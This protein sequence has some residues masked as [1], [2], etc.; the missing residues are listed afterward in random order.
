M[1][2]PSRLILPLMAHS[3]GG[4]E[5][6][7]AHAP[8]GFGVKVSLTTTNG[9]CKGGQFILH[10]KS[11]PGIPYDGHTLKEVLDETEALTGREIERVYVDKGYRGHNAPRP[12]RVFRSGQKRGVHGQIKKELRRRSTIEALIGH[13]KTDGH[14]G[15]NF[16]KGRH[17]D[18]INA[19]MRAVGYNFRLILKWLR[20]LW[21]KIIAAICDA[22]NPFSAFRSDS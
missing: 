11:L 3:P 20:L 7:K 1:R 4:R 6:I 17:G 15:R 14:L 9:R 21:S 8:Y 12:H 18:Q 22:I 13:C 5:A 19:V 16:L 2:S 10:A